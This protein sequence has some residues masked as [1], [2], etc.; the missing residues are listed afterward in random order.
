MSPITE[1]GGWPKLAAG[2]PLADR[3]NDGIPDAWEKEQ[4]LN[5]DD[6]ED[7]N[8]TRKPGGYTHL[9]ECLNS[10]K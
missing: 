2:K 9:E 10:I 4:G 3:D 5:P 7:C 6:A 8:G 1:V